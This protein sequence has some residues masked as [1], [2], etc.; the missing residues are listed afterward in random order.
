MTDNRQKKGDHP[1][2][3]VASSL[4]GSFPIAAFQ[5][6]NPLLGPA[7]GYRLILPS[8]LHGRAFLPEAHLLVP[9]PCCLLLDV[10]K[11]TKL[12]PEYKCVFM[13]CDRARSSTGSGAQT[14]GL[15]L[16]KQAGLE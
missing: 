6:R 9:F 1:D 5:T 15:P 13:N 3:L 11:L 10:S 14:P 16:L 12:Y 2:R 8:F 7:G 4:S